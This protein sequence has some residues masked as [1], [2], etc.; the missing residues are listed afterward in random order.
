MLKINLFFYPAQFWPHKNHIYILKYLFFRKKYKVLIDAVF[1]GGDK[2]NKENVNE[3][4]ANKL[5]I[6]EGVIF[7]GFVTNLELF[8]F[9][10]MSL[11][12][13]V[14][15]FGQQMSRLLKHLN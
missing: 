2:G 6:G 8:A 12:L 3:L 5:G 10:K 15:T 14:P 4:Y 1:A 11:A 9:Y 7:T 13:V